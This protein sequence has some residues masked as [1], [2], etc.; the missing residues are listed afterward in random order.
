MDRKDWK[1]LFAPRILQRG[2]VYYR[3]GAVKM[4]QRK[5]DVVNAVV[6]GRERYRVEIGLKGDE[7]TD[8]SC[9]CPYASEGTPCKHMA[10]V[11]Y[12]L[13]DA[14]RE[15]APAP[16]EGQRSIRA[17]IEGMDP[18]QAQA[19]LLRLAERDTAVAEQIR[20]ATEPPS[21]QQVQRWKRQIARLLRRAAEG[22]GYIEYDRAWDTMCELDDLLSDTTGQ[23]LAAG[24]V[25]E[26]FS[27]TGYGFQAAAQCDMDDSDGG[28]TMLA[29]TCLGLWRA[30][31][32]AAAP[33][34]RRRMY[35]W[36][37][38][39]CRTSDDLCQELSWEAQQELFHAPEFLRS[40][41]AQLDRM[42]REEQ[43]RPDRGYSRLPQLV[44]QKLERMEEL[45]LINDLDYGRR[46]AADA[47]NLRGWPRRRIAMEL[48]KKGVPEEVIEKALA[49]ITEETEIETACR[50]LEGPYRGK[51]RDRRERD[52]VKAALQ[53][54]GFSYE[55]I[56][57]AVSR[58][59]EALPEGGE[60][61]EP[62]ETPETG[63]GQEELLALIRKKYA[64]NMA[65][66]A[67]M[68][69]TIAALYRRGYPLE[70]IKAAMNTILEQE[71]NC[72][73]D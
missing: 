12:G 67:G 31:I 53:R 17:R 1:E 24:Y 57:Q 3:E 18:E 26:A 23:L 16:R 11:F 45:G 60:T 43:A 44:I 10:A 21:K 2:L 71:E 66:R 38:E 7:I 35:Q 54:R 64:K 61:P 70:E 34:L 15:E 32:E 49:D 20:S 6:L 59:M 56:R 51:L 52:K 62:E 36:F 13:D 19:L 25:W 55:V 30:Q 8:W 46:Y 5:G 68:E 28:L 33:D 29:E 72:R 4:L 63:D 50:L 37:Q 65:D 69:K 42:I 41:I 48:Q 58:A 9:D 40:N 22:H 47:V 27:L 14:D 39:V 73:D